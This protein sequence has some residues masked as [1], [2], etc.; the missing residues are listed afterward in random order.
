MVRAVSRHV[1]RNS[2]DPVNPSSRRPRE[3]DARALAAEVL[4]RLEAEPRTRVSEALATVLTR[5]GDGRDKGLA[6]ELVYGVVR[7]QRRI[8]WL[9]G[10]FMPKGINSVEPMARALLRIGAYQVRWLDRIPPEIAV[11]A[12]QDAARSAGLERLTGLLNAVLRKVVASPEVLPEGTSD[13]AIGLRASLPNWV[14]AALREVSTDVEADALA[15][16]ERA[17]VS[18]RP[19][20]GRGGVDATLASLEREGLSGRAVEHGLVE[21]AGGDPFRTAGM[22]DGLFV[23]QDGAGAVVVDEVVA[24]CG[25]TLAGKRILD[26]CAGRGV[27]ATALADRGARVV[28][29]DIARDKLDELVRVARRL[30]VADRIEA[31]LA[32]DPTTEDGAKALAKLGE[33]D[34]VLVDAP[35]TGLGTLRRHPE[36]AW[37]AVP[38]DVDAL[39]VLQGQLL[40]A[41]AARVAV[42]G[43][44]VYA[45]CSFVRKEGEGSLPSPFECVARLNLAPSSGL[46]AFQVRRWIRR[47]A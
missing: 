23:A 6:T 38:E 31:T 8:D 25:G 27:K 22:R 30:G 26:L 44:V 16:R 11:S 45:V 39:A 9:L 15:L 5:L 34:A 24:A 18:L 36:I 47:T 10:R 1:K 14:V 28:A 4:R 29:V 7:W 17:K 3:P 20:L 35:C 2:E 12:T 33:F 40:A 19:T 37:R 43:G 21:V 32:I 41:G 42:G 46:D 13:N